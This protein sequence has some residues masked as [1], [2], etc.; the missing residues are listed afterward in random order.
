MGVVSVCYTADRMTEDFDRRL[1]HVLVVVR[2]AGLVEVL[3]FPRLRLSSLHVRLLLD[4]G[5][6][7]EFLKSRIE[8]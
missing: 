1:G 5:E 8:A 4:S 2:G 3:Q 6:V 7:A